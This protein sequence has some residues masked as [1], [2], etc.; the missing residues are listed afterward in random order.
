MLQ[1]NMTHFFSTNKWQ[2]KR[3]EEGTTVKKLETYAPNAGCVWTLLRPQ[4]GANQ[5]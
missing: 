3:R 1:K 4:V 5:L 2:E